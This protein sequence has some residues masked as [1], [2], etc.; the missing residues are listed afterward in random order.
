MIERLPSDVFAFLRDKDSYPQEPGSPV[1]VLD[2]ITDG[3]PGLGTRYREVV[4][5]L[6]LVRGEILSEVTRYEPDRYLE[7]QFK[8]AG[9]QGHLSYE[10]VLHSSGTTLIQ[11][12]TL[13]PLGILRLVG[14]LIERM[15]YRRLRERL[16]SIKLILESG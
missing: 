13:Q 6:P 15:L 16:E 7:E 5:M 10:F 9:M 1:L 4:Q 14:P 3:P 2:K 8:G 12:E 11:R